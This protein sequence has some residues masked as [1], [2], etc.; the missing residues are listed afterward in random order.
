M[1]MQTSEQVMQNIERNWVPLQCNCITPIPRGT[2]RG[3][4]LHYSKLWIR[5][6]QQ[7]A[8]IRNK[9]A[10]RKW[11]KILFYKASHQF[12]KAQEFDN[13]QD[14]YQE[15]FTKENQ[16]NSFTF[17]LLLH[18]PYWL[19]WAKAAR[20]KICFFPVENE[21]SKAAEDSVSL[22]RG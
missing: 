11:S 21:S 19:N 3:R 6:A 22:C 7:R 16:T 12:S 9:E 20:C 2:S 17:L 10:Y 15:N 8:Y 1:S 18:L 13:W 4:F 14:L 5:V